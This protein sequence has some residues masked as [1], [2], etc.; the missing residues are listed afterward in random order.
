MPTEKA[1]LHCSCTYTRPDIVCF[2]KE[3]IL[4]YSTPV[5]NVNSYLQH[6]QPTTS[7]WSTM[8]LFAWS[9]F[10]TKPWKSGLIQTVCTCATY[11]PVCGDIVKHRGFFMHPLQSQYVANAFHTQ[12]KTHAFSIKTVTKYFVGLGVHGNASCN[13]SLWHVGMQWSHMAHCVSALISCK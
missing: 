11:P 5:R 7:A 9:S 12:H 13:R 4:W 10:I 2:K 3:R 1:N 6:D 8:K